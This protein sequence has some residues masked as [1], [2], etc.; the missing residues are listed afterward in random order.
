MASSGILRH[1]IHWVDILE[2]RRL[3][4]ENILKAF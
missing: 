4:L 2:Q 3:A 1:E